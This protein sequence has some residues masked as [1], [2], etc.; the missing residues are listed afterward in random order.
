MAIIPPP[1]VQTAYLIRWGVSLAGLRFTKLMV[2]HSGRVVH[3]TRSFLIDG[4]I[5]VDYDKDERRSLD[6]ILDNTERYFDSRAEG[7]W[8]DKVI[9]AYRG[10]LINQPA[11]IPKVI[12]ITD[13]NSQFMVMRSQLQAIGFT[14]IYVDTSSA[15]VSDLAGYDIVVA[16]DGGNVPTKPTL[17]QQAWAAGFN[18][19]TMGSQA[20]QA[21]Y[22]SIISTTVNDTG[23]MNVIPSGSIAPAVGWTSWVTGDQVT[24]KV[25][26][27]YPAGAFQFATDGLGN[28]AGV[29]LELVSGQRRAHITTTT[30]PGVQAGEDVSADHEIPE[31]EYRHW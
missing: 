23:A 18:V 22:P 21:H 8:Y 7:F 26:K 12:I 24:T 28:S 25:V 15:T 5:S 14:D 10:L 20:T 1:L 27:T 11:G 17:I 13:D 16:N 6:L 19:L 3:K 29:A 2:R 30:L 4:T 9:K 31:S